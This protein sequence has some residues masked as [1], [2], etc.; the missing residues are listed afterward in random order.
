MTRFEGSHPE[1]SNPLL[2]TGRTPP[3]S[4]RRPFGQHGLL[5]RCLQGDPS[6]LLAG[7]SEKLYAA[8]TRCD[9]R[10]E[11][12]DFLRER[13]ARFRGLLSK[14]HQLRGRVPSGSLDLRRRHPWKD[15]PT[16]WSP[17]ATWSTRARTR[18][19]AAATR[20]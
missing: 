13:S 15:P 9:R 14:V 1:I 18:S 12:P 5:L 16:S 4:V 2:V 11:L 10:G 19:S 17:R 8:R 7:A 20:T 6:E 3:D